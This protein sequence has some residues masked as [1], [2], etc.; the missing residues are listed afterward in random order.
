MR[1][2]I[3]VPALLLGLLFITVAALGLARGL[4]AS[5]NWHTVWLAAPAVLIALG[6]LGLV[7][8][9]KPPREDR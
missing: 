4:G 9:R 6:G 2:R 8:N 7:L 3:D 1:S 5:I